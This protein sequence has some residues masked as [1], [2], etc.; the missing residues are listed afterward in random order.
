MPIPLSSLIASDSGHR[1]TR[2]PI[3]AYSSGVGRVLGYIGRRRETPVILCI[4]VEPD[5]RV[6]DRS[7]P[8]PWAGFEGFVERLPAL[9]ERLSEASGTTATFTWFLRMDPQVAETYGSPTWV[10]ER[11]AGELADLTRSGDEVGLHTHLWRWDSQA[12]EWIADYQDPAWAEQ[13]V[14]MSLDAFETAFGR[15]CSVHRGGDHFLSGPILSVL[16]DRGLEIDLTVEPGQPPLP[17]LVSGELS[18]GM[19]PDYRDVPL[20]PYRSNPD[21]FPAPDAARDS[22]PLL[23]PLLSAPRSRPPFRREPLTVW[24]GSA[25]RAFRFRLAAE[26]LR[27]APPVIALAVRSDAGRDVWAWNQLCNRLQDLARHRQMVFM[28]AS[29]AVDHYAA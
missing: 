23:V 27:R 12:A 5:P 18:R 19:L 15:Q 25:P 21:S 20:R 3:S 26:L 29:G 14:T 28:T 17:G 4:D 8:P 10:S 11:Y 2:P 1:V 7:E 24:D 22:G 9:R 16:D 13:C 6:V